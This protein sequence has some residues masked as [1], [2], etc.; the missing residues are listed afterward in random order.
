MACFAAVD[1]E[2]TPLDAED[3]LAQGRTAAATALVALYKALG[4]AWEAGARAGP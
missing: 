3:R 1:A 4:G 2:R